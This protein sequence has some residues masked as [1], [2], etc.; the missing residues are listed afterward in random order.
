MESPKGMCNAC[1]AT[2]KNRELEKLRAYKDALKEAII[3]KEGAMG[4]NV[5]YIYDKGDRNLGWALLGGENA[6]V[7]LRHNWCECGKDEFHSYPEDG[8]CVCGMYK[9][10]V[11]CTCGGVMQVG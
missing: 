3:K 10:H 5:I 7:K 6:E 11:H 2:M 4:K 9:H 8:Q 1:Y